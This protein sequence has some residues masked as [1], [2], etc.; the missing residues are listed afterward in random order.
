MQEKEHKAPLTFKEKTLLGF[1]LSTG[2]FV[3]MF[4]FFYLMYGIFFQEWFFKVFLNKYFYLLL[5]PFLAFLVPFKEDNKIIEPI[6][7]IIF[8]SMLMYFT[9]TLYVDGTELEKQLIDLYKNDK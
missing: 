1:C 9:F 8:L 2:V 6:I 4:V 3:V 7:A 5:F